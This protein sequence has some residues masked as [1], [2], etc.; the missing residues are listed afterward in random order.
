MTK[1]LTF[2]EFVDSCD[3][4]KEVTQKELNDL[5]KYLDQI[6]GMLGIDVEFTRHFLDRV[7]D[8][9]NR[10]QIT[11]CELKKL[12]LDVFKIHGTK[13]KQMKNL[14]SV[15][16]DTKTDINIPFVLKF[17]HRSKDLELVSKTVM[18]KKNFVPNN[19]R[20]KIIAV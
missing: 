3:S 19:P 15:L 12:F 6:W 18:R 10:K 14:E 17:N 20:E 5:E 1:I 8:E 7:N 13:I 16:K 9:R 4:S 11:I 2:L